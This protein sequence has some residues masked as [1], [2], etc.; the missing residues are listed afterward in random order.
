MCRPPAACLPLAINASILYPDG[1]EVHHSPKYEIFAEGTRHG[2]L[3]HDLVM[4]DSGTY[5]ITFANM[6][7]PSRL[8]VTG[9]MGTIKFYKFGFIGM[10]VMGPVTRVR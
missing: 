8:R 1:V 10:D 3:V 9:E 7:F 4:E 5:A 2:L 6:C